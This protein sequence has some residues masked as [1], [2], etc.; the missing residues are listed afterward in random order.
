MMDKN[1]LRLAIDYIQ[2]KVDFEEILK[3]RHLLD[4]AMPS[5]NG[6]IKMKCFAHDDRTPSLSVN[7]YT[8]RFHCFSCGMH[9]RILEFL[10]EYNYH[11]LGRRTSISYLVDEMLRDDPVMRL[12]V[13]SYTVSKKDNTADVME[14]LALRKSASFKLVEEIPRTYP[15]LAIKIRKKY[16]HDVN[17]KLLAIDGKERGM[18][19]GEIYELLENVYYKK[20]SAEAHNSFEP[21]DISDFL[22]DL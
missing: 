22:N 1:K 14:K 16:P 12:R 6:E 5:S 9:G 8:K 3:E 4:D 13:G 15:E 17:M 2:E 21:R 7:I 11:V 10:K 18:K 19:P 20:P